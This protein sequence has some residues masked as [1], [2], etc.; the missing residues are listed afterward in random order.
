MAFIIPVSQATTCSLKQSGLVFLSI[1]L[2]RVIKIYLENV[3]LCYKGFSS[4]AEVLCGIVK[5]SQNISPQPFKVDKIQG[6]CKAS[7]GGGI[8]YQ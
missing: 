2:W 7:A 5:V 3:T 6:V 8:I 4:I 1:K